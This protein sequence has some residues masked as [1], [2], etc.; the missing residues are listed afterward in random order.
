MRE[1]NGGV[2]GLTLAPSQTG[3]TPG[4]AKTAALAGSGELGCFTF[5]ATPPSAPAPT[6]I[7]AGE[8]EILLAGIKTRHLFLRAAL[9]CK[10]RG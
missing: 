8:L 7:V 2:P 3:A 4:T 10:R 9:R 1:G 5:A 6:W